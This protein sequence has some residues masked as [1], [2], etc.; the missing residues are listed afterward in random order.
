VF[1]PWVDVA[2]GD[3]FTFDVYGTEED[4]VLQWR[5]RRRYRGGAPPPP[6]ILQAMPQELAGTAR[7]HIATGAFEM[8][9]DQPQAEAMHPATGLT[10]IAFRMGW[11]QREE[12]WSFQEYHCA[13]TMAEHTG[14]Q[15]FILRR[16]GPDGNV[17]DVALCPADKDIIPQ[18]TRDGGFVL[19]W[20]TQIPHEQRHGGPGC[21]VFRADTGSSVATVSIDP[22]AEDPC[23]LEPHFY[24]ISANALIAMDLDHGELAWSWP[25]PPAQFKG[26][27]PLRK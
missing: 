3:T 1:P 9:S 18:V 10:T 24:C 12:P 7:I 19:V 16:Q 22:D 11:R 15:W 27:P 14:K 21:A 8:T 23:V 4:V 26:P 5:A 13:L 17:T 2:D 6:A 20:T 25:L